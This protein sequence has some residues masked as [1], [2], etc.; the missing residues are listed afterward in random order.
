MSKASPTIA[1][2]IRFHTALLDRL[3]Q[4]EEH[5]VSRPD[6][7]PRGRMSRAEKIRLA[8]SCG[9]RAL[10]AEANS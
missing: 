5:L 1:V 8:L 9:V 2:T 4:L 3:D 7:A 10:E 6:Y